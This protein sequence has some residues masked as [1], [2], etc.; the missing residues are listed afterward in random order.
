MHT[1]LKSIG[2]AD[3]DRNGAE[4]IRKDV[5]AHPDIQSVVRGDEESGPIEEYRKNYSFQ[6]GIA[7]KG[8]DTPEGEFREEYYYPYFE[9]QSVSSNEDVELVR[10]SDRE[11]YEGILDDPRLG[12]ELIFYVIDEVGMTRQ[13]YQKGKY[14]NHGQ[15]RLSGL[16]SSAL[17]L[18]PLDDTLQPVYTQKEL[19][20]DYELRRS[21]KEGD[22]EA[23]EKL[24]DLEMDQ[25]N[26]IEKRAEKEDTLTIVSTYI[27]PSGIESDKYTVLG[28]I[29]KR[30]KFLNR[31]TR[32]EVNVLTLESNDIL[33]DV[34]VNDKDLIGDP[35]PGRRLK[36]EIWLQGKIG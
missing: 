15:V 1:F 11:S 2:F 10:N 35:K 18:L 33:L 20:E 27:M 8:E 28:V 5:L 24:S 25:F 29:K 36:A 26:E 22:A 17:V 14:V 7:I 19:N 9:G 6:M 13:D 31:T 34:V 23:I 16:A 21:A 32:Q 30:K 12:I 3:L 4:M